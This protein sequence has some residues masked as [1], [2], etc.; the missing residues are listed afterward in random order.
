MAALSA[1]GRV[2]LD[3]NEA[4]LAVLELSVFL[5]SGIPLSTA[6]HSMTGSETPALAMFAEEVLKRIEIGYPLSRAVEA[7][8]SSLGPVA[9]SVLRAGEQT[10][11]LARVLAE[12]SAR[13]D[14][15]HRS[16]T[17][18]ISALSYPAGILVVTALMVFFMTSYML[19]RFLLAA[20]PAL[21]N[22]PWPTLLLTKI[23]AAGA[24]LTLLLLVGACSVPWFLSEV[25][26]AARVRNWV[27]YESPLIGPIGHS[28]EMARLCADLGLLLDAGMTLDRSLKILS[29]G[30]PRIAEALR[31]VTRSLHQGETF[32]EAVRHAQTFS[33]LFEAFVAI[34]EET[35]TLPRL[36]R[37]QSEILEAD[38]EHRTSET[39]RLIEPAAL[40]LLGAVVGF[41]VLGCFLPIYQLIGDNL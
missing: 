6:L 4:R 23:A 7:T 19:P 12:L 36:L 8:T 17:Q 39:I 3:S 28:A 40:T 20:G 32:S 30:D 41:V 18:L 22:P 33:R 9:L 11:R 16:R 35:G 5:N 37:T 13:M 21:K 24:P 38:T 29:P 34:G 14:R 25:P 1:D 10:G 27:M 26:A 15:L 31:A 2:K